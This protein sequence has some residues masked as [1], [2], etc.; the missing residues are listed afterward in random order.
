LSDD[1]Y[2]EEGNKKRR[3]TRTVTKKGKKS[4]NE[5]YYLFSEE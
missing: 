3:E 4:A 1:E 2:D 5:D